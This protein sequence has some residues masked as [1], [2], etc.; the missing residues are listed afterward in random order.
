LVLLRAPLPL[1]HF[2]VALRVQ[3]LLF[4]LLAVLRHLDLLLGDPLLLLLLRQ[5]LPLRLQLRFLLLGTLAD[6]PAFHQLL[7]YRGLPLSRQLLVLGLL[8]W[9]LQ[10]R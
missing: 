8:T 9:P 3:L 5:T 6:D 7:L 2:L 1:Q 4:Q 10:I